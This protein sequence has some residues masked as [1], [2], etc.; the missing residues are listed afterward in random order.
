VTRLLPG[1]GI[2]AI[3]CGSAGKSPDLPMAVAQKR[4]VAPQESK[5]PAGWTAVDEAIFSARI[6]AKFERRDAGGEQTLEARK[7]G[8]LYLLSWKT[9]PPNTDPE[10]AFDA[11]SSAFF[12]IC[13]G[14]RVRLEHADTLEHKTVTVDGSCEHNKPAMGQVH[15]RGS[16]LFQLY[17][18]IDGSPSAVDREELSGFFRAFRVKSS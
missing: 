8:V 4:E 1:L 2:L 3:A 13:K 11:V 12:R 15:L 5:L 6:P 10:R 7:D 18:V 14:A 9:L 17:I 16:D